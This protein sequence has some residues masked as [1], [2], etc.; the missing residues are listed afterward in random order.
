MGK[1]VTRL[2]EQFQPENY[3]LHLELNRDAMTFSGRVTVRGKKVGRPAQRLTFHQKDLKIT[4]AK[5]VKH[6]KKGDQELKISRINNQNSLDEVRL[7]TEGMVYPGSYTV[8]LEFFGN[9]RGDMNGIYPCQFKHNDE[10]KMLLATQFESHYARKAFPCIDE[11]EAK[12]TFDLTLTTPKNEVTL[13]NTPVK[14]QKV[15]SQNSVTTFETTPRMSTY[16]LAFVTGEMHRKSTKTKRG[17]EVNTWSTV[18]QPIDSLDFAVSTAKDCI[19]FFENY[20]NVLYPL[21]K[22]DYVALPD[23][24]VGAMENWGLQTYR[25]RLLVAYPG[26]T[27]QNVME[28]IALVIGHET[29]HQWFGDLVTMRWWDDLWL[30]ES[31]AN[32]MEYEVIDAIF[33]EWKVWDSFIDYEGLSALRRDATPGVQPVKTTVN[34]PDEIHTIFDHSI[35]YSKGGRL[36]YMLKNYIGEEAFRKGLTNYFNEH[37]YKNTSG[38]DLW[39]ALSKMSGIDV[40]AFMNPWLERSGFPVL[41]VKQAGRSITIEQEHFLDNPKKIDV[42]RL[43]PVPLFANNKSLPGRIDEKRFS[44]ELKSDEYVRL[45]TGALGHYIVHYDSPAHRKAIVASIKNK[46]LSNAERLMVLNNSS[47]LARAGYQH[48][49]DVLNLLKAYEN[50]T[51]ESV[52]NVLCLIIGEVKRFIDLEEKLEV[53]IKSFVRELIANEYKRLGWEEKADEPVA[54]RKLRATI[55]GLGAYAENPDIIARAKKLFIGYK[56][57]SSTVP[58]ELRGIILGVAVKQKVPGAFDYLLGL[59]DKTDNSDLKSDIAL[60]LAFTH[61]EDEAIKLLDRLTDNTLVKPQDADHWLVYLLRNRYARNVSW[62][63][64]TKNWGWIEK[65]Y[66][67]EATYDSWPRYAASICNTKAWADKYLQFFGPK[68]DQVALKRN[69][70]IGLEEIDNRVAWL[71]RDLAAVHEFFK[72]HSR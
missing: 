30:N 48:Y 53:S 57:D 31:F 56:K 26:E 38:S 19:E 68:Q 45:N 24:A 43:W 50:E 59:H 67:N 1:K 12:A 33:P 4:S 64:M 25:E 47:M 65:T 62:D 8:V 71:K 18:A 9:I 6:D 14:H 28:T 63:W 44:T 34:H 5:V 16:L 13:S 58:N 60:A 29:S 17:T 49:G 41:T 27:S 42:K 70:I 32:M 20:F 69:I 22:A 66:K 2:F 46:E 61:S 40:G 11:P 7:H 36:L 10:D 23:F 54:D 52:W 55:I 35:V 15:V 37:A 51:N 39:D 21:A 72:K 3:K